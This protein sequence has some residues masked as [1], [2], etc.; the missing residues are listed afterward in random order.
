MGASVYAQH[1]K[2][3]PAITLPPQSNPE[4]SFRPRLTMALCTPY[5]DGASLTW[6][7]S[8]PRTERV[9]WPPYKPGGAIDVPPSGQTRHGWDKGRGREVSQCTDLS[10]DVLKGSRTDQGE[11]Y[12]EHILGE[13]QRDC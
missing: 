5:S 3:Q 7:H 8:K 9:E 10:S 6:H 4:Q 2:P 1:T 11:A 12:Q 13:N